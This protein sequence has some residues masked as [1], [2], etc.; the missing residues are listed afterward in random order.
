[1]QHDDLAPIRIRAVAPSR[2]QNFEPG[3]ESELR[4]VSF[5]E[6]D[7]RAC[8]ADFVAAVL[9]A[10]EKALRDMKRNKSVSNE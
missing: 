1:M 6:A 9:I 7:F 5:A 2:R 4:M 3:A 10:R 8:F